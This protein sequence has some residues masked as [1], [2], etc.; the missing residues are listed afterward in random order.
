L[1]CFSSDEI[2][3]RDKLTLNIFWFKD[4][5]LEEA[6]SRP[7]PNEQAQEIAEDL[8]AATELL[9]SIAGELKE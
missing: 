5:S 8:Q 9:A 3:K 4:A 7:E 2:A 1:R 6:D